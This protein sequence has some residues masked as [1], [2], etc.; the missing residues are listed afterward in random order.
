M[1]SNGGSDTREAEPV[2]RRLDSDDDGSV[3][4]REKH[5]RLSGGQ[6]AGRRRSRRPPSSAAV[7]AVLAAAV[8]TVL[9]IALAACGSSSSSSSSSS[10]TSSGS[11]GTSAADI[12]KTAE[13]ELKP[14]YGKVPLVPLPAAP[15]PG[16]TGNIYIV[17]CGKA[18][19][20]CTRIGNGAAAAL[21]AIGW[22][23]TVLDGKLAPEPTNAAVLQAVSAKPDGIILSAVS[24]ELIGEGLAAAKK[25]K[26]PV[27]DVGGNDKQGTCSSCVDA[28]LSSEAESNHNGQL[29]GWFLIKDSAGKANVL[30][31]NDSEFPVIKY[32]LDGLTSVLSKC[33]GCKV[34][35]TV[36]FTGEDL[37]LKLTAL[38]QTALQRNPDVNYVYVPYGSAS[39]FVAS[40]I[41]QSGRDVKIALYATNAP[42]IEAIR[43]GE[44]E[45][46]SVDLPLEYQGWRAMDD[47]IR[48][49][50]GQKPAPYYGQAESTSRPDQKVLDKNDLPPVGKAWNGDPETYPQDLLKLWGVS[51]K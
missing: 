45:V 27:V 44:I 16:K 22:K 51:G 47:L 8:I 21:K 19:E 32:Q 33:S 37:G 4:E 50:A 18:A 38:V 34:A 30:A 20:G 26:I 17:L 39:T 31:L 41:R 7:R 3:V 29:S 35:E 23:V 13:R 40:A 14:Y 6:R 28:E 15:K 36:G 9:A 5:D 42:D 43:K 12:V 46:G 24:T 10:S 1:I 48:L 25:A 49:R 2:F 11:S